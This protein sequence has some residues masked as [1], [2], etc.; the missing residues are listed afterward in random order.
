MSNTIIPGSDKAA[1]LALS[2]NIAHVV[3]NPAALGI[4]SEEGADLSARAATFAALV[5]GTVVSKEAKAATV[6]TKVEARSEWARG[7]VE[8][9]L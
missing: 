3:S 8:C 9:R 4:T 5:A 6:A 2:N 1:A 7:G